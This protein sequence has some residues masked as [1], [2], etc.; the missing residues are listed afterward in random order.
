VMPTTGEVTALIN[1]S[2][3]Y[4]EKCVRETA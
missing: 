1:E 3:A 2:R 4:V